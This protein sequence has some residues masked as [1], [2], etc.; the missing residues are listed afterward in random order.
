MNVN[1]FYSRNLRTGI[2]RYSQIIKYPG[3]LLATYSDIIGHKIGYCEQMLHRE[4]STIVVRHPHT[5]GTTLC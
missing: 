4:T 5:L 1:I 2:R 3:I